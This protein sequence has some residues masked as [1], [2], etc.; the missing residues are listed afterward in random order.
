MTS[1]RA[2]FFSLLQ[3]GSL[4]QS[5]LYGLSD[6]NDKEAEELAAVWPNLPTDIRRQVIRS[7]VDLTE[8]DIEVSF[9][10]VFRIALEDKDDT[11]REAAVE[12]LWEDE[13]VRL[14]PLL[15]VRLKTDAA[16]NV[17]AVAAQSLG[18]FVLLGELDKIRPLPYQQAY[19]ALLDGYECEG[20]CTAVLRRVLESLAYSCSEEVTTI[21]DEAYR[22]SDDEMRVSAVFAM[23]RSGDAEWGPH[24]LKELES[25]APAMRYE[26][27]R[28]SGEL[29]LMDAVPVLIEFMDDVDIEVQ[30]AAIWALGQIGGEDARRALEECTRT[31][32]EAKRQAAFEAIQEYELLHGDVGSLLLPLS[33]YQKEID[34]EDSDDENQSTE[35]EEEN[36]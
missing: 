6:L 32:S 2:E 4:S 1:P 13:D 31:E 17:R 30:E 23:G 34:P 19:K 16:P 28:A 21:I 12:G 33:I 7:L 25:T 14:V 8:S 15:V 9:E 29:A 10:Q 20:E 26:A 11:V 18:R 24:V 22:H 27:A 5:L 35:L 3:N 36:P